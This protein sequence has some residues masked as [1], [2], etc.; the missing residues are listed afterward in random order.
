MNDRLAPLVHW[1]G[2]HSYKVQ[3]R[4]QFPGGALYLEAWQ[5]GECSGLLSRSTGQLVPW[6]RVPLLP[7][8][9]FYTELHNRGGYASGDAAGLENRYAG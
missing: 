3:N 1:L 6:V 4:V 9:Q 2:P 7:R 5:S 8:T